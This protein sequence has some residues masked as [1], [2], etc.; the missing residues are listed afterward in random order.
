MTDD[1]KKG[2]LVYFGRPNGEKTLATYRMNRALEQL[3]WQRAGGRCDYCQLAQ[4]FNCGAGRGVCTR[5][6]LVLESRRLETSR[7]T[8]KRPWR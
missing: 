7:L 5:F 8:L 1:F 4:E 3:P 2:Q 6:D